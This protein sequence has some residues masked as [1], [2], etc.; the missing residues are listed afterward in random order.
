MLAGGD[1]GRAGL[2]NRNRP[3]YVPAK[4]IF[5]PLRTVGALPAIV[6]AVVDALAPLGV[7]GLDMPTTS[8]RIW[9]AIRDAP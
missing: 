5:L 1:P 3:N 2:S 8:E 6:N 7:K 9:Q 4:L